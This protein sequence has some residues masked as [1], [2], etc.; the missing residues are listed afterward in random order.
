MQQVLLGYLLPV[1]VTNFWVD[2]ELS[3]IVEYCDNTLDKVK[4]LNQ[5]TRWNE[6]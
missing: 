6:I 2:K 5:S 3:V 1:S 4:S